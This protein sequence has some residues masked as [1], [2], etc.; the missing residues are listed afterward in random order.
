M[1]DQLHSA[2]RSGDAVVISAGQDGEI[3]LTRKD[4]GY[5][6]LVSTNFNVANPSNAIDYPC[7]R[8]D[9]A[10]ELLGPMLAGLIIGIM[11][12]RQSGA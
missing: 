2:D 1:H 6:F 10:H 8:Y 11:L 5:G 12:S 9:K 7:W 3:V 4:P